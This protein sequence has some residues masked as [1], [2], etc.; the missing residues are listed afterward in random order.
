MTSSG[1][2]AT[3]R[4]VARKKVGANHR[5]TGLENQD[6]FGILAPDDGAGDAVAVAVADGHGSA[7]SFRSAVGSRFGVEVSIQLVEELLRAATDTAAGD[8]KR[9]LEDRAGKQLVREWHKKVAAHLAGSP[10]RD[11]E[12][13]RLEESSGP[14]AVARVKHEPPLAY[15][16]TL[17]SAVATRSFMVFWQIGDGDIVVVNAD[18]RVT[19]P[20]P[21]DPELLGNATTSLCSPDAWQNFRSAFTGSLAPLVLVATDGVANSYTNEDA[22]LKF[23]SDVFERISAEGLDA[24]VDQLPRW[25]RRI[26]DH[27]SGDDVSLGILHR[28]APPVSTPTTDSEAVPT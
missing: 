4:V 12:L 13:S 10:F 19:R 17:L 14:A 20:I 18:G 2:D 28:T 8:L 25:L 6:S 21:H 7:T 9:L 26:S 24:V 22:F 16:S 15:G 27:G 5:R 1:T 11:N 23:G 3:W